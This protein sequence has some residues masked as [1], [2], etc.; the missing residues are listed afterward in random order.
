MHH[1]Q[2]GYF[3][4]FDWFDIKYNL[5]YWLYKHALSDSKSDVIKYGWLPL[6]LSI[7]R[8]IILISTFQNFR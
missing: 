2:P 5:I 3:S 1:F 8:Y 7:L 6:N 4:K